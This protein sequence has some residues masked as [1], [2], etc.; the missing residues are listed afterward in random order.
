[1]LHGVAASVEH[2]RLLRSLP[3]RTVI[4]IGANRGQFA[5]AAYAFLPEANIISF[6][7]LASPARKFRRLFAGN[8]RVQ[9]HQVAIGPAPGVADIHVSTRDDA[10]SLLPITRLR[11]ETFPGTG[12]R[13]TEKITVKRLGD[14]I[15]PAEIVAPALLKMDVQGYE[16]ESLRGCEELL[17]AFAYAY[18]ECSFHE[19]YQGQVYPDE[20]L[21]YF[22][23]HGFR[24]AGAYNFTYDKAGHTLEGDLFFARPNQRMG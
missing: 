18:V 10:S 20:L 8:A 6:E 13:C 19:F 12:E 21:A 9:L 14:L 2:K 7:P 4:D 17:A 3:C 11:E 15:T 16:L 5:L 22:R 23:S 24:L 1:L